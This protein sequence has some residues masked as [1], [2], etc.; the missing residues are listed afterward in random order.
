MSHRWGM[1]QHLK[2]LRI[3]NAFLAQKPFDELGVGTMYQIG[4]GVGQDLAEAFNWYRKA[5]ANKNYSNAQA[6]GRSHQDIPRLQGKPG[7][8]QR[9]CQSLREGQRRT[10]LNVSVLTSL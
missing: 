3:Y 5:A 8:L 9:R 2:S 10:T 6:K 1:S 7:E 4:W